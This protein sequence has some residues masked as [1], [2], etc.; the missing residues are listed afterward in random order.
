MQPEPAAVRVI[1]FGEWRD[2]IGGAVGKDA[3]GPDKT[4]N[5]AKMT[6]VP[7]PIRLDREIRFRNRLVHR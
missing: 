2:G 4:R 1:D 7:G 6:L 5:D 3:K